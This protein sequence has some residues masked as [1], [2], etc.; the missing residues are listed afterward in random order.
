M[1]STPHPAGASRAGGRRGL[2]T[3]RLVEQAAAELFTENGYTATSMQAIADAAGVHVQTIY[4]AY[5]T[6]ASVLAAC[7]AR[8]VAGE[9]D[10]DTHPSERRWAREIQAARDPR[11]QIELYVRHMFEVAPR[12]TALIDV[13]RATAAG[14]PEVAAFLEH[15]ENARREGPLQLLGPLAANATLRDDLTPDAVADIVFTLASPDT[16]R[17][18]LDRCGWGSKRAE[19]WLTALLVSELLGNSWGDPATEPAEPDGA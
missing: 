5:R 4:L 8:L 11:H 13:L 9:E 3:R 2:E 6:K 19:K 16:L 18:L 12:I 7:A 15:M 1:S 10:P 14:E 17:S